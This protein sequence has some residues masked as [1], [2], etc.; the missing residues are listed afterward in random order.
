MLFFSVQDM[1]AYSVIMPVYNEEKILAGSVDTLHAYLQKLGKDF[2]IIIANDGSTDGSLRIAEEL[3]KRYPG[4]RVVSQQQNQGRG[5][6]LTK[7]FMRIHSP[8]G[9]YIDAD[10][11]IGP[12]VIPLILAALE[13]GVGVAI[14]S[15]HHPASVVEYSFKRNVTSKGYA[16]LARLLLGSAVRDF[17]CGCKGFR[18]EEL[19]VLLPSMQEAGWSWDTEIVVRAEWHGFLVGEIPVRVAAQPER[20]SKVAVWRDVKRM[21]AGLFRLRKEKK[22]FMQAAIM[23][24]IK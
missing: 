16:L 1:P 7:A 18:K 2:E 4:V 5:S 3:M 14:G 24:T 11:A 22:K 8:F 10:L 20:E 15:K 19:D 13:D 6:I 9:L 12:G 21:A 23:G 17:Q